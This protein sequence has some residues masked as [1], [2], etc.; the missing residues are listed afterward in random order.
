MNTGMKICHVNLASGYSGGENQTL[1]LI[2]QQLS[3]GYQLTVI[4]NP[5]SPFADAAKALGCNVILASHYTRC[6]NAAITQ[7]CR[8]IHVHEG[9][10]IYWALI[11]H[12]LHN[13]PYI[14]TRRIDNPLK[15]R[16]LSNLAYKNAHTLV[17]ISQE[18]VH[19]LSLRHPRATLAKI[20]SSPVSYPRSSSSIAAIRYR[21]A[22]KFLIIQ[23]AKLLKHK[24]HDVT[25]S[26]ARIL[27]QKQL[28]IHIALLGDGKDMQEIKA[29]AHGLENVS[30]E[31][32]QS[33]MGDWFAAADV[34]IH[35]SY[36]EGLG[37]VIL[38][39][40]QAGLPV[41]ASNTGGIPDIICHDKNGLLVEPGNSKQLSD[42]IEL[43]YCNESKRTRYIQ[44]SQHTL[45]H[46]DICYTSKLYSHLYNTVK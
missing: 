40:M 24:G 46:F 9:R 20:P 26:A 7:D 13:V 11:Q 19:Q 22:N 1:Q 36:T 10:A 34:L 45:E 14:V 28:P 5:K 33:N 43:M 2:K 44:A 15:N 39:A 3:E 27:Q 29:L 18:V 6:H 30:F 31:G 41:I 4:A 23:A 17:G 35:P 8:A 21:F 32:K 42:S 37:S 25:L 12:L 16:W 38:E